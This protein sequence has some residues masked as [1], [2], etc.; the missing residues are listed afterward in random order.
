MFIITDMTRRLILT[1]LLLAAL[2]ACLPSTPPAAEAARPPDLPAVTPA[3]PSPQP[4]LAASLT[5]D[6][7]SPTPLPPEPTVSPSPQPTDTALP[8]PPL[9]T[10]AL[11]TAQPT[12]IPQPQA[13]SATIQFYSPGPLSRVTSPVS[14]YG[15]AVPGHDNQG[16]IQLFGEDGTV[17]ASELLQLNTD[18]KWA[19]FSWSLDFQPRG[20]AELGRLTL[21]TRDEFGRR[22]AVQSVH[23]LLFSD[24]LPVINPPGNLA[25]RCVLDSPAVGKR[26]A[27]GNLLVAGKM[28]P[29]NA[30]PLL[31]ELIDRQGAVLASQ[32]VPIQPN[33]DDLY[34]PFSISL[35]YR[36]SSFTPVRLTISQADDRIPGTMYLYSQEINLNP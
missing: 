5:P 6:I 11:P 2:T 3:Q 7:V 32:E 15:Y 4:V 34:V 20:A 26:I 19:F 18:Y 12:A 29:Y 25:E 30:S 33:P 31:I 1:C 22:M 13:G 28:R 24:G 14:F 35:P 8:A 17:L 23:L 10:L 27:G 36:V 16:L 21:T 9:P